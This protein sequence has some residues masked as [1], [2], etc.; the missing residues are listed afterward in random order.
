MLPFLGSQ[1]LISLPF[2]SIDDVDDEGD[3]VDDNCED[4][5]VHIHELR[6]IM[7]LKIIVTQQLKSMANTIKRKQGKKSS[8]DCHN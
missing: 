5:D 4:D 8:T 6:L 7:F 2:E 1:T 3:E